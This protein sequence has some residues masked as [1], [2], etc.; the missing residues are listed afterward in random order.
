MV[1]WRSNHRVYQAYPALRRISQPQHLHLLYYVFSFLYYFACIFLFRLLKRRCTNIVQR[2][3]FIWTGSFLSNFMNDGH[4]IRKLVCVALR[5]KRTC[6]AM[7]ESSPLGYMCC[8]CTLQ[9]IARNCTDFEKL[10]HSSP[11]FTLVHK[12]NKQIYKITHIFMSSCR[13]E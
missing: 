13:R 8:I 10:A 11:K 1:E 2:A 9:L 6:E 12:Q 4:V 7:R 5:P 3:H